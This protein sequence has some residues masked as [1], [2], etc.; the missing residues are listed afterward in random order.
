MR[1]EIIKKA[2]EIL[3]EDLAGR[4]VRWWEGSIGVEGVV[5]AENPNGSIWVEVIKI[6]MEVGEELLLGSRGLGK[7]WEVIE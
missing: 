7:K 5:T 1:E 4:K 3:E 2:D 6:D